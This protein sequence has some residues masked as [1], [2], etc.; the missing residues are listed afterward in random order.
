MF[1]NEKRYAMVNVQISSIL[2]PKYNITAMLDSDVTAFLFLLLVC[3][4]K[5]L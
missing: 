2:F 5:Y 1:S 3:M 4:I